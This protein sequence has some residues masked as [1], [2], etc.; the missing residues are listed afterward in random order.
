[1]NDFLICFG[2]MGLLA[3]PAILLF[4]ICGSTWRSK[5]SGAIACLAF[6]VLFSGGMYAENKWDNEAWNNGICSVC[7]GEY[8]FS[9]ATKYRT[10][11]SY[12]YTCDDCGHTIE[13]NSLMK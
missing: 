4:L 9:G 13:T 1:M 10:S 3:V 7:E 5:I 2:F 6:W 11:H 8:N 12:Y